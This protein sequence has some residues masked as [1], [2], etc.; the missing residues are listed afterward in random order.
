MFKSTI[1]N[2]E[3]FSKDAMLADESAYTKMKHAEAD[4]KCENKTDGCCK[5]AVESNKN[6][7]TKEADYAEIT[8]VQAEIDKAYEAQKSAN[9]LIN[10]YVDEL[11]DKKRAIYS[12]ADIEIKDLEKEYEEKIE[13]IR[14]E[15]EVK[16]N[17]LKKKKKQLVHNY[18]KNYG[19]YAETSKS[20][21]YI[22][23]DIFNDF[24]DEFFK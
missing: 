11:E 16:I 8:G 20:P 4:K 14:N 1:T 21:S 9:K 22:W 10:S 19:E 7:S 24:F 15:A 12:E 23:F 13:K 2:K 18:V 3:Y 6:I 17:D 5:T